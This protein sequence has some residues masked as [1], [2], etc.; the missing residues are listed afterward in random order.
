MVKGSGHAR[1]EHGKGRIF[2]R[3]KTWWI[4]YYIH[5]QQVR[6]SSRSRTKAVAERLLMKRLVAADEGTLASPMRPIIYEEMRERLVTAWLLDRPELTRKETDQA[7]AR[8]DEFFKG[9]SASVITEEKI[10]EFKLAR[11]ATGASNATVNRS[12]AALRQMFRL[13]I[14]R[15]KNP[16]QVKL[17]PEPPARQG[18]LTDEDYLRLFSKLPLY[19][20]PITEFAYSTGMRQGELEEL[21]WKKVDRAAGVIRLEPE[22][23]KNKTG[24]EIHYGLLPEL[25]ESMARLWQRSIKASDLVF[26]RANGSPLGTFRKAWVRACIKAALGRMLWYC[27]KCHHKIEVEKQFWPPE[28]QPSE[29]PQCECGTACHWHYEG[30]I[31]H[32]LRRT[33]VRNLRRAGVPESVVM[34][35]SGHKSR[36]VFERYNIKDS[37]DQRRAMQ[38]LQEFRQV[39]QR[40]PERPGTRPN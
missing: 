14:K 30:L 32:D 1:G 16:S 33:A 5:G 26:T 39:E 9:L 29:A 11:K 37:D 23:T 22:D 40:K 10:D 31:F 20:Q 19:L 6:E 4:Q 21:T 13:S 3:G 17:L 18:F 35:I 27:S 15:I 28:R 34:T 24:R 25:A 38:A 2:Q 12:L 7:L 36:E 8:L